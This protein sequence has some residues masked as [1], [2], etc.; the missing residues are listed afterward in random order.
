[1]HSDENENDIIEF[2]EGYWRDNHLHG[3]CFVQKQDGTRFHGIFSKGKRD[4]TGTELTSDGKSI[5]G[6]WKNGNL[7]DRW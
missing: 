4:G 5:E 3:H 2:T 1:M 7:V 6:T